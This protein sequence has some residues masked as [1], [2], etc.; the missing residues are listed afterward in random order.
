MLSKFAS[1]FSADG[2][3]DDADSLIMF[4]FSIFVSCFLCFLFSLFLVPC[5]VMR[6]KNGRLSKKHK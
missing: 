5:F 3:D 6:K 1:F 4:S 2:E